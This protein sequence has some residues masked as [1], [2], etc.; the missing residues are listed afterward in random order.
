VFT[1]LPLQLVV[2]P[3]H[4]RPQAPAEQTWPD[5][6]AL[7]HAPQLAVSVCVFTQVPLQSVVPPTHE[8]PQ[9]PFEQT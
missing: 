9:V 4:V 6:Q 8:R 7:P 1:Q 3:V 5:G 2:P